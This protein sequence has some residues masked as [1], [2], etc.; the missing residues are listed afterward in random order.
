M[1]RDGITRRTL[2]AASAAGATLASTAGTLAGTTWRAVAGAPAILKPL[3]PEWFVDF[4]TNAEMRWESV[5]PRRYLTAPSRLFVRNHTVTPTIDASSYRL[6]VLG[7]AVAGERSLSLRDLRRFRP[8]EV[9]TVH[10]CTGNG[11]S[12]FG[13]QQG[14]TVSGTAWTLGAVG[15]VTWQG[16]RLADVLRAAGVRRDAV[17][18]Q[19][20]GLDPS[21]VSGG[22]DHGPVRRPF[23]IAKA[24][25]DA[26]LAW[27]MNGRP[28]LPDHGYPLRLVLPGWVGIAS[29]KW[30]GSLEV[31]TTE[32][33]SPWNTR[34]Y[35]M[36]GGAYPAD[37]PP[38]TL[39][40]VRSA[41][42]L[43]WDA[44]LPRRRRLELT[45][46]SWSG[47]GPIARVDVSLDGGRTW[48][49]ARLRDRPRGVAW[50]R[51]SVAWDRPTPGA[52]TLLARAT[53]VH[54]RT[55]PDVT[56]YNSQ[57]YFFDAVVQ[58]PVTVA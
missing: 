18:V 22:V 27:G 26:L 51:W 29:I 17:S 58:H 10:E 40:P 7:D 36:S 20:T 48:S 21:F 14:E 33:T 31:S 32:L 9:T 41:W 13:S 3:P 57:G 2:L 43:P 24:Y 45:G 44:T 15:T 39:N 53:D 47:A 52:H 49:R 5:D 16:V 19:A 50:T 1:S 25:D 23:P 37:A 35:R 34:W 55:Q 54:G 30:L 8:V 28:L 56:P 6:R 12:F 46:R 42:E 38:L 11:R 4:G